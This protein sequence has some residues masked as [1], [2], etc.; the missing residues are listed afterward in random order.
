[1]FG[2]KVHLYMPAGM[3]SPG[4]EEENKTKPKIT[5]KIE[6]GDKPISCDAAAA[7]LVKGI[8]RGNYQITNDFITDLV[9]V[10]AKGAVPGNGVLDVAYG[11]IGAVSQLLCSDGADGRS[12]SPSGA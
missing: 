10:S 1:M 5:Q 3:L 11:V 8:E 9:R 7:I 12:A 6:E 2:I 4:Y